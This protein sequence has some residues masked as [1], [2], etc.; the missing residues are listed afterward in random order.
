M[1]D[2][3]NPPPNDSNGGTALKRAGKLILGKG[4]SIVLFLCI[5]AIGV[6]VYV[7]FAGGDA[8]S[9]ADIPSIPDIPDIGLATSVS[10]ASVGTDVPDQ[11]VVSQT[12]IPDVTTAP[13]PA[14]T[15]AARI[16]YVRPLAGEVIRGYSASTPVYNPTMDDWRVHTGI[17]IAA[18]P[19]EAVCS[20]AAGTVCDVYT[21]YFKGNVV[22]IQHLDGRISIYCGLADNPSAAIGDTVT[23]GTVIGTVGA[24]PSFESL[25]GAHLHFEMM[26]DGIQLDPTLYLPS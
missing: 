13:K 7:L 16:F 3:K 26:Q 20:V 25:D 4:F 1:A 21:D 15:S 2:H 11:S 14:E 8:Q 12:L 10:F 22:K 9:D 24:P 23:A 6:S 5:A 18:D 17:D 19:G